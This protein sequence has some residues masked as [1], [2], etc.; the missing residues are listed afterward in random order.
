MKH[1]CDEFK[2]CDSLKTETMWNVA[3][4]E[5]P[6]QTVFNMVPYNTSP[7]TKPSAELEIKVDVNYVGEDERTDG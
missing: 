3:G 4:Y 2:S 1:C 5:D 6:R 7:L